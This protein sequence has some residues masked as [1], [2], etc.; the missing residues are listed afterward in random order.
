M[1]EGA[2]KMSKIPRY[3]ILLSL[4]LLGLC[5]FVVGLLATIAGTSIAL[6]GLGLIVSGP[7]VLSLGL[8]LIFF[9]VGVAR[10][11]KPR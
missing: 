6:P 11:L 4:G 5:L 3:L 7:L 8:L 1:D 10:L 9:A 2:G